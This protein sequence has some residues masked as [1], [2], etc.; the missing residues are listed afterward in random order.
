[1]LHAVAG[2]LL[3]RQAN[4]VRDSNSTTKGGEKMQYQRPEIARL[5]KA[6]EL[7]MGQK[8]RILQPTPS[9]HGEIPFDCELDD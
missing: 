8:V 2:L 9:T 1:M 6:T 7:I 4:K 5:G 3:L